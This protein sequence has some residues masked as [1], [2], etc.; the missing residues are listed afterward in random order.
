MRLDA[1]RFWLPLAAGVAAAGLASAVAAQHDGAMGSQSS[2][3][4]GDAAQSGQDRVN[5]SR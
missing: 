5:D 1:R 3:A 4:H 2:G